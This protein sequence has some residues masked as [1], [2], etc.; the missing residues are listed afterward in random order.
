M[1]FFTSK[2]ENFLCTTQGSCDNTSHIFFVVF[3]QLQQDIMLIFIY[4][5]AKVTM[6]YRCS[7]KEKEEEAKRQTCLFKYTL[8]ILSVIY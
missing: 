3:S 2:R 6:M 5:I 1:D 4:R 7:S 8:I